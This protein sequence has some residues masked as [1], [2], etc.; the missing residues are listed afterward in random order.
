MNSD[1]QSSYH[2]G[3][4]RH[5]LLAAAKRDLR[6]KGKENLSLRALA[7]EIGVSQTA[8]YRHFGD[9]P[10]LLAALAAQGFTELTACT[11][12]ALKAAGHDPEAMLIGAGQTYVR[13]ARDNPELFKLMFGPRP[14]PQEGLEELGDARDQAFANIS[15]IMRRGIEQQVFVQED[16]VRLARAAWAMVHGLAT[17]IIDHF[18]TCWEADELDQQIAD[19]LRI[20]TRGVRRGK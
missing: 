15:M 18:Q 11:Q 9:K 3:N 20:F 16:P 1:Q 13:Y 10:A 19:S 8:P 14:E 2:H 12:Q 4:L 5:E 7:R 17:L 6:E